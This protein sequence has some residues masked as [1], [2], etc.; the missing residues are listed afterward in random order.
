MNSASKAVSDKWKHVG[1]SGASN[2]RPIGNADRNC[3]NFGPSRIVTIRPPDTWNRNVRRSWDTF[4]YTSRAQ[5]SRSRPQYR[6][7]RIMPCH[8][9]FATPTSRWNI[10]ALIADDTPQCGL[11]EA[12]SEIPGNSCMDLRFRDE[13]FF[14]TK[15]FVCLRQCMRRGKL[16]IASCFIDFEC[17]I[18]RQSEEE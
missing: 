4:P 8:S 10:S 14:I 11:V 7:K 15:K 5:C 1:K 6:P 2:D 17:G 13:S 9:R 16:A 3:V 12:G 18:T